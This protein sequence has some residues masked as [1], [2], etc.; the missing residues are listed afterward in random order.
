LTNN[1][2]STSLHATGQPLTNNPAPTPM[3][4]QAGH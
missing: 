1:T 3:H 4:L 2:V